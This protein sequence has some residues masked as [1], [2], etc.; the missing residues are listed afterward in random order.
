MTDRVS[1][2][3]NLGPAM[4]AAFARVGIHSAEQL[5]DL[6]TDVAYA[7]LLAGGARP[8]FIGFYVIEMALQGRPWTDC[9]G[10][11]KAALR[12][13]FDRLKAAAGQHGQGIDRA[14]D[15][16]LDDIGVIRRRAAEN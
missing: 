15:R 12:V 5:R 13:R 2:L 14:M 1:S 4:D 6:G 3:R 9:Q 10:A 11:E 8:H 16:I 7:K